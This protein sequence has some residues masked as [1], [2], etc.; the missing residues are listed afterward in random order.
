MYVARVLYPV[1]V[2]GP[3]KR[4]GIW[5]CGCP[6]RCKG[7]S[8]PEL[9]EFQERYKASPEMIFKLVQSIAKKHTIDGFTITGGE[10]MYQAEALQ[11]LLVFLKTISDD[12]IVY[13]GYDITELESRILTNVS[14]LIDGE[15]IEELNDN[16]LLRGSSNQ[17]IHILDISKKEKYKTYLSIETNKIQNFFTSDGVVSVGKQRPN[18]CKENGNE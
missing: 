17:R 8:N 7:C 10:P 14:V 16:S 18:I 13:T 2:L 1:E 4:V 9:W 3:G 6:R 5:F 15:Y 11:H 12:I